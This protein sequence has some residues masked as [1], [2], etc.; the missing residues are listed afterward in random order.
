MASGDIVGVAP[1]DHAS[2]P[3]NR[4]LRLGGDTGWPN[5]QLDTT[6]CAGE[7]DQTCRIIRSLS[8]CDR[9]GHISVDQ[10]RQRFRLPVDCEI[11]PVG[12]SIRETSFN[13]TSGLC[14][15]DSL[16]KI[17][18]LAGGRLIA[19][20]FPINLIFNA[21]HCDECGNDTCPAAGL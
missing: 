21:R 3:L 18:G 15:N 5:T 17:I 10:E 20:E 13:Y 12:I 11:M 16:P 7:L 1:V 4:A 8:G 2:G 9:A 19:R 14:R 6:G